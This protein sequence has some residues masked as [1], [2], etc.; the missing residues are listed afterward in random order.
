[1]ELKEKAKDLEALKQD[2]GKFE[3]IWAQMKE[4]NLAYQQRVAVLEKYNQIHK[5]VKDASENEQKLGNE[6]QQKREAYNLLDAQWRNSQAYALAQTLEAGKPCVVC[7]STNHPQKA[8]Q[9]TQIVTE[10][11]LKKARTDYDNIEKKYR[12]ATEA[13]QEKEREQAEILAEGKSLREQLGDLASLTA[14]EMQA[15]VKSAETDFAKAQKAEQE[16][17]KIQQTLT[18]TGQEL[19]TLEAQI[20]NNEGKEN[21]LK[22]AKAVQENLIQALIKDIP[23]DINNEAQLKERMGKLADEKETAQDLLHKHQQE[24]QAEIAKM[25]KSKHTIEE[26]EKHLNG[27]RLEKRKGILDT[28]KDLEKSIEKNLAKYGF[29]ETKD[30][31]EA[32][33][34]EEE[35]QNHKKETDKYEA[36]KTE[37]KALFEEK[38]KK[39]GS[40]LKPELASLQA[41]V[42]KLEGDYMEMNRQLTQTKTE[43]E[44]IIL[45]RNEITKQQTEL[46]ELNEMYAGLPELVNVANGKNDLRQKFEIFVLSVFL[47]EVLHYANQRL[48]LLSNGRYQLERSEGIVDGRKGAGMDLIVFDQYTGTTRPVENLSGGETFFTSLALALGL[49]DTAVAQ[50]GGR[51]LDAM[52]IDEGFGTLD[53]ETLDL[54]IK[55]LHNLSDEQ[56]LV[57]IISHVAELKERIPAKLEVRKMKNGSV[58][59]V[60]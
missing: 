1:M 59:R 47:D 43:K 17:A 6:S 36:K 50:A 15:R 39:V 60:S 22:T 2:K 29:V 16:F 5:L 13:R 42:G 8:T 25:E 48:D 11:Q 4:K 32:I 46:D 31:L 35:K 38:K 51:A 53:A 7:G 27:N 58:V 24:L 30:V 26:D 41:E 10:E 33:L 19:T 14:E 55:T 21:E 9:T 18:T 45:Q 3:Q 57:G 40:R 54:A 12:Q 20:K 28:I 52:F 56:R 49:A 44:K 37:L 23:Q 34:K